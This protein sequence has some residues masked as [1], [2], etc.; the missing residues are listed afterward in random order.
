M[1]RKLSVLIISILLFTGCSTTKEPINL[2]YAKKEIKE[3]FEDSTRYWK[4][5]WRICNE[6]K[7]YAEKNLDKSKNNI[8]IFD[9]DETSLNNL[10]YMK[11]FDFGY[12]QESWEAWV[13]SAK[14]TAIQPVLELYLFLKEKG[15]K[16]FFITGRHES[17]YIKDPDPTIKNLNNVGFKNI[18]GVFFKPRTPKMKTSEFKSQIRKKLVEGNGYH[19]LLNIGDQESDFWGEYPGKVFKLP[20]PAYMTF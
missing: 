7:K 9:I 11:E 13:D 20:N 19:I 6:A 14:A 2:Y 15:M 17:K 5:V 18:D 10:E 4:E 12:T 3:Y 16:I 1:K 8:A